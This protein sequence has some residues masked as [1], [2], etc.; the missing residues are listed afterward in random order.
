MGIANRKSTAGTNVP[1]SS[2]TSTASSHRCLSLNDERTEP[3]SLIWL[4]E[5][6]LTGSL[7]TLRTK[8]LF[9]QISN[10]NSQFFDGISDFFKE[11]DKIKIEHRK[12]LVVMSGSLAKDVLPKI[13]QDIIPTV[14]IF[15]RDYNRYVTLLKQHANVVSICI[16]QERLKSCIQS[17]LGSLKFNLFDNQVLQ[18]IRPLTSLKELGNN[19]AYFSYMLFIELLKHL[20]QTKHAKDI[21]LDK[22]KDYYRGNKK[23]GE[24]IEKFRNNYTAN[25]AIDWYT[26]DS[27]VYRLINRAFRT[28]DVTLWYLFRYYIIDLC[29]QLKKVH[30]EQNIRTLMTV[31]R[32][33]ARTPTKELEDLKMNVGHLVSV[34]GFFSTSTN[35]DIAKKFIAGGEHTEDFKPV[36]FEIIVDGSRLQNTVFVDIN[37][38]KK[39]AAEAEILFDI[40]SVFKINAIDYNG[41]NDPWIIKMEATDE[42]T[43]EIKEKIDGKK[44]EFHQT[45]INL[46][47]G[48]LLMDMNECT[49]A[50]SYFQMMLSVLPESHEDLPFIYDHLGDLNMIKTNWKEAF[51]NFHLAYEMKKKTLPASHP[52]IGL[53]LNNIG[54]YYKA[55]GDYPQAL[56]WYRKTLQC[57]QNDRLNTVKTQLNITGVHAMMHHFDEALKLCTETLD[58]LKEAYPHSYS[59]IIRCYGLI[60]TIYFMQKNNTT[61]TDYYLAAFKLSNRTLSINDRLR[62]YSIRSVADVCYHRGMKQLA[63]NFCQNKLFFYEKYLSV[64]HVNIAYLAMKIGEFLEND[65]QQRIDFLLRALNIFEKCVH[66]EYAATANCLMLIAK[67]YQKSETYDIARKYFLRALEIYEKI[68]PEGHQIIRQTQSIIDAM[69]FSEENQTLECV[70]VI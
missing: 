44:R 54:N 70:S 26:E 7:D 40:G 24:W 41:E 47:L 52:L 64:D 30:K 61:A 13:P 67:H 32:G 49:K 31:Y 15:C 18:S 60:G 29:R 36:L 2:S 56:E 21:M 66:I 14:I 8:T 12:I 3:F 35:I 48:R 27:F 57:Q 17:E 9:F 59:E 38:Y 23:Q 16:D 43:Y 25:I 19:G 5:N 53:T 42:G 46:M 63:V 34:N 69:K 68:Y 58:I 51:Y 65:A 20:P 55:I 4:D 62:I 6:A 45:N 22:C 39:E 37:R 33:Q 1:H 28:D 50:E 11:I 10:N